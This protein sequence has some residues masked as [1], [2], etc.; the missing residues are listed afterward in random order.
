MKQTELTTSSGARRQRPYDHIVLL[1]RDA[2]F[3][4]STYL[5]IYSLASY[6]MSV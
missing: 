4:V 3:R 1:C 2:K 6:I 5:G